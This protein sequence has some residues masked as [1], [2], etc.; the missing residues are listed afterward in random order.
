[1]RIGWKKFLLFAF[2]IALLIPGGTIYAHSGR[3]DSAGGHHDYKNASGL[4][5]YHYHHGYGPHLHS[6]GVCPYQ[7]TSGSSKSSA[8]QSK[9]RQEN[10]KYQ[11]MLNKLGFHCGT[12][13]GI[14]GNKSRT[15]IR[16]FQKKHKLSVTGT[17]NK[18]TKQK[19]RQQYNAKH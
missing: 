18:K 1:M 15:S 3:T 17:L 4:G 5:S 19:I 13:D 14:C 6:N 9:A 2:V 10:K 12:P 11:E 8:S 7:T 16:K